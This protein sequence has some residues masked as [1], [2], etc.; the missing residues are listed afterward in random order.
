M[1]FNNNAK[2]W[3][4]DIDGTLWS[5]CSGL[6]II[7]YFLWV[8]PCVVW[9]MQRFKQVSWYTFLLMFS[10]YFTDLH[11]PWLCTRNAGKTKTASAG[12]N[13]DVSSQKYTQ[14]ILMSKTECRYN[15]CLLTRKLQ[16][17]AL[18]KVRVQRTVPCNL[19]SHVPLEPVWGLPHE[20]HC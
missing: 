19:L 9:I 11:V 10:H 16:R 4:T 14:S 6:E 15:F 17:A 3:K 20:L 1:L 12:L 2:Q 18:N 7:D 8:V 13:M 5:F